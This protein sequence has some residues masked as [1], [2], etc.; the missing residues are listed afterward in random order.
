MNQ[1]IS[2]LKQ[3]LVE[4]FLSLYQ[5]YH[6]ED[7][8]ACSLI[9]NEFLLVDD[10]AIST[11][12][13]IFDENE[14]RLQY[15]AEHDRWTV[16]KW[17][18]QSSHQHN[19][20]LQQFSAE[21]AKYFQHQLRLNQSNTAQKSAEPSNNFSLFLKS[22][23]AAILSL[24]QQHQLDLSRMIFFIH[25]PTQVELEIQSAETLNKD[26]LLLRHFLFYKNQKK[27]KA[28]QPRIK[29]SQTDKD[30]LTD[31]GQIVE[32]EPYDYIQVAHEAYLLTL[33]PY[34]VDSNL[35]IQKLIQSIAEMAFE[36]DGSCA[37]SKS[38]ILQRL[39]QFNHQAQMVSAEIPIWSIQM[40]FTE[41]LHDSASV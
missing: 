33:E 9:L 22:F 19:H 16:E 14:D 1:H 40:K 24:K 2:A 7:I 31:L 38:E 20:E 32:V 37:M 12:K 15:L 13:S 8:Y 23:E 41:L 6:G 29:L 27:S 4:R 10:L 39:E 21:L 26:S 25:I 5:Q 18:Y 36:V 3:I 35:Y 34:F 17:R 28:T 11:E 30:L